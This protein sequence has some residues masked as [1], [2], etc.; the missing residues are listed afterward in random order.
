MDKKL[1][2]IM[3]L[4]VVILLVILLI[5]LVGNDFKDRNDELVSEITE[6]MRIEME[7]A[8]FEGQKAALN[9]NIRIKMTADGIYVWTKS[10]WK[11]GTQPTYNPTFLD[12]QPT[13]YYQDTIIN[14][15]KPK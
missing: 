4:I 8:Y 13:I 15:I 2:I 11:D 1:N 12:S 14:F 5:R 6:L 9:G 10:C 3:S 7:R